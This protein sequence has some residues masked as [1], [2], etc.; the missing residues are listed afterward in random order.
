M[1]R[2]PRWRGYSIDQHQ[3]QGEVSAFIHPAYREDKSA[4]R[5]ASR[6]SLGV[7]GRRWILTLHPILSHFLEL[8]TLTLPAI[9]L[10]LAGCAT[11]P[12][13][14]DIRTTAV[15]ILGT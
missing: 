13:G 10:L 14:A 1:F 15:Q 4:V 9:C 5:T 12:R 2:L 8:K 11:T 6:E 3:L 7:Q